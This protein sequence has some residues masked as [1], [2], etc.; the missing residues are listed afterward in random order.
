VR[1]IALVVLLLVPPACASADHV[2]IDARGA[3]VE[4]PAAPPQRAEV[5]SLP[6]PESVQPLASAITPAALDDTSPAR[7]PLMA[8]S[9]EPASAACNEWVADGADAIRSVPPRTGTYACRVCATGE[10]PELALV[11]DAGAVA[12][13]RYTLRAW[14][15]SRPKREAPDNVTAL[16][17][18]QTVA[19]VVSATSPVVVPGDAYA[20][21]IVTIDLPEGASS[22]RARI[23]AT[24]TAA[25]CVLVDD[26]VLERV[27]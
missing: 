22:I 9:F 19:G 24:A 18:A 6:D 16:V 27:E 13:G 3:L 1:P 2:E 8:T 20:E 12:A 5:L 4:P 23:G 26:V 17:E 11:R 10:A 7:A 15:R 21:L 14:V 25:Q